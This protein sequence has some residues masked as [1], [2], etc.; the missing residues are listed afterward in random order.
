MDNL[1]S[2]TKPEENVTYPQDT[3]SYMHVRKP[4]HKEPVAPVQRESVITREDVP[5]PLFRFGVT[6][7]LLTPLLLVA[8]IYYGV[9]NP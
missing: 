7:A 1:A 9:I 3:P 8:A 5:N 2:Q 4:E 6:L